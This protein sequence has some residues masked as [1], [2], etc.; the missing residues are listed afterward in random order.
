MGVSL[1][2]IVVGKFDD[3]QINNIIQNCKKVSII[4]CF[5]HNFKNLQGSIANKNFF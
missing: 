4:R 1:P 5:E 3:T 2:Y